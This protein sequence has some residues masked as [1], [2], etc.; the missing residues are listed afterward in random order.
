[1]D[2]SGSGIGRGMKWLT[3][4]NVASFSECGDKVSGS[5]QFGLIFD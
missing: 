1:M 3:L 4:E 5:I 2:L